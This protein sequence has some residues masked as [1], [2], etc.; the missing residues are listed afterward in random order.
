MPFAVASSDG[1][2]VEHVKPLQ[3]AVIGNEP[4]DCI[5]DKVYEP[6]PIIQQTPRATKVARMARWR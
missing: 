2:D 1:F 6:P 5:W 3:K 4:D